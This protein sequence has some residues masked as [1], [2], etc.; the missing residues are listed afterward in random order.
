MITLI[1]PFEHED[2]D[3]LFKLRPI[4][5][6]VRC[7]LLSAPFWENLSFDE[8]IIY[9]CIYTINFICGVSNCKY[10]IVQM[11]TAMI[12][13]HIFGERNIYEETIM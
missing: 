11:D 3:K 8:Q 6:I 5:E 1:S 13:K 10:C 7:N 2:Y 9:E 12:S 4:T